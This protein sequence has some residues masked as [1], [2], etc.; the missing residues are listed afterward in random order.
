MNRQDAIRNYIQQPEQA[1]L[2]NR[3]RA[4]VQAQQVDSAD[5]LVAEIGPIATEGI[6]PFRYSD[7]QRSIYAELGGVAF[8]DGNYTV[9]G[10]VIKGIEIID[11]I[12]AQETNQSDRPLTDIAMSV[13]VETK[14]KKDIATEYGYTYN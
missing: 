12:A 11:T 5:A 9:F 8:L 7:N 14:S 2:L 4:F 1:E 3:L 10:E 13:R 6:V